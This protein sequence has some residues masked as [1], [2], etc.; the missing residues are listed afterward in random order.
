MRNESQVRAEKEYYARVKGTEEFK[1]RSR[2]YANI[3][4]LKKRYAKEIQEINAKEMVIRF[5]KHVGVNN[6]GMQLISART[7]NTIDQQ[8]MMKDANLEQFESIFGGFKSSKIDGEDVFEFFKNEI[9]YRYYEK[10]PIMTEEEKREMHRVLQKEWRKNNKDKAKSYRDKYN[11]KNPGIV[12][13]YKTKYRNKPIPGYYGRRSWTP[14]E[15]NYIKNNLDTS[16]TDIALYLNRS[17]SSVL[18][19][20]HKIVHNLI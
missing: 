1:K 19:R 18:N 14:E 11:K 8:L 3:H 12:K 10:R 17:I 13:E 9:W 16:I 20:K 6:G 4:F 5:A 7:N 15:D 2:K